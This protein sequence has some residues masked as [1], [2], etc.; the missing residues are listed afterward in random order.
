MTLTK[1]ILFLTSLTILGSILA[2]A[3]NIFVVERILIPDPCYYHSHETNIIFDV[4]Y[5]LSPD[6]GYHPFPTMFN[7]I[8]TMILGSVAGFI[9]ALK[10]INYYKK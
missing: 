1:K 10:T 9:I 8:F 3:F 5:D 4:F 6:E 7:F 2:L